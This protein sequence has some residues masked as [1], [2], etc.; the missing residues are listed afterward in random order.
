M[1][2]YQSRESFPSNVVGQKHSSFLAIWRIPSCNAGSLPIKTSEGYRSD[3]FRDIP[4]RFNVLGLV[5]SIVLGRMQPQKLD[6]EVRVPGAT[7]RI[8][9]F[10]LY[11]G[12]VGLCFTRSLM[13]NAPT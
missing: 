1:A 3:N 5:V 12:N 9:H 13:P 4:S 2:S 7:A 6:F 8:L 11:T 10:A